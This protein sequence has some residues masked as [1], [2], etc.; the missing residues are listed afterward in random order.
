MQEQYINQ[1]ISQGMAGSAFGKMETVDLSAYEE[2]LSGIAMRLG[3]FRDEIV[4]AFNGGNMG[5]EAMNQLIGYIDS[6]DMILQSNA[7]ITD[8]VANGNA[9]LKESFI[10]I[11]KVTFE[12]INAYMKKIA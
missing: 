9:D 6:L 2:Q 8:K 10:D 1:S 12:N 5:Q 4:N 7:I 11:S 3:Q